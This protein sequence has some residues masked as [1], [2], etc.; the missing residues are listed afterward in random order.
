MLALVFRDAGVSES[1]DCRMSA[2]D[3]KQRGGAAAVKTA[4]E[5]ELVISELA[6]IEKVP[7]PPLRRVRIARNAN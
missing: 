3:S 6:Q 7:R 4:E 2:K 1:A 5:N